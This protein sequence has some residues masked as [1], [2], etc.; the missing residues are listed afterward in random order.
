MLNEKYDSSFIIMQ[1]IELFKGHDD[2][3]QEFIQ[4]LPDEAQYQAEVMF[5]QYRIKYYDIDDC[6]LLQLKHLSNS[7]QNNTMNDIEF[8]CK[9]RELFSN[10]N[11]NVNESRKRESSNFQVT[12]DEKRVDLEI[13]F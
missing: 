6:K 4:F 9:C 13:E 12:F 5:K 10:S 11:S 1:V 2:L 8:Y 3:I 7:Y